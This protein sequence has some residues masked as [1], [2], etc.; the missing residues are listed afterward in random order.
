MKMR[1]RLWPHAG[2]SV[3]VRFEDVSLEGIGCIDGQSIPF[4]LQATQSGEAVPLTG[5]SYPSTDTIIL[6][7]GRAVSEAEL[8]SGL[9]LHGGYGCDPSTMPMDMGR[10]MPMLGFYGLE[11]YGD[12]RPTASNE[13]RL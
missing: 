5:C 4:V 11:V 1:D 10:V 3:S 9:V 6:Q 8:R 7:C 2:L 13:A 12:V